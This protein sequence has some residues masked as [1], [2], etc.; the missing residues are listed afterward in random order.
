[1][2]YLF[3]THR[4]YKSKPKVSQNI[5]WPSSAHAEAGLPRLATEP[6]EQLREPLEQV[7]VHAVAL[8]LPLARGLELGAELRLVR[9]GVRLGLGEGWVRVG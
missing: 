7:L 3:D 1:M 9:V 6:A 8:R 4:I 5:Y 2:F